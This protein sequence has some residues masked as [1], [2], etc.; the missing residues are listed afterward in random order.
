MDTALG[1]IKQTFSQCISQSLRI[2]SLCPNRPCLPQP[3]SIRVLTCSAFLSFLHWVHLTRSC[4]GLSSQ[5]TECSCCP[6]SLSPAC[7]VYKFYFKLNSAWSLRL[8]IAL[9]TWFRAVQR[10]N[11]WGWSS[12]GVCLENKSHAKLP[13]GGTWFGP[14]KTLWTEPISINWGWSENS[15]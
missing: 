10:T 11:H 3:P 9:H 15:P 5:S 13:P 12:L 6:G 4:N 14:T 7:R 2:V 1:V 8:N